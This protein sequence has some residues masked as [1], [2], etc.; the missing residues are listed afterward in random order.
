MKNEVII[1]SIMCLLLGYKKLKDSKKDI[2]SLSYLLG[3][4]IRQYDIPKENFHISEGAKKR[5]EE[6]SDDKIENYWYHKRVKCNKLKSSKSY[7]FYKGSEN[8]GIETVLNPGDFFTFRNM[9][10]EEHIIPVSLIKDKMINNTNSVTESTIRELL[11]SMHMC[12]ILKE[13]DRDINHNLGK[14]ANRTDD[15]KKNVE[16]IY[17]KRGI[18]LLPYEQFP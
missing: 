4:S 10:H 8:K 11:D 18:I 9:F 13:E 7:L 17:D 6:L 3:Q 14:T 15:F 5:W 2:E 1:K 16:N 12:I